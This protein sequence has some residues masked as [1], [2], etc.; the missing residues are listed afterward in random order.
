MTNLGRQISGFMHDLIPPGSDAESI[1]PQISAEVKALLPLTP[2]EPLG[3][4]ISDFV[5]TLEESGSPGVAISNFLDGLLP[6]SPV[7]PDVPPSPI[8]P[9]VI[10]DLVHELTNPGENP[11]PPD[12]SP[13]SGIR[14]EIH[15]ILGTTDLDVSG[16]FPDWLF[17]T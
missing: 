4:L 16:H 2:I 8:D 10:R 14:A 7:R 17:F 11:R 6:P 15:D 1:G 3:T 13:G 9:D 12:D 5:Q